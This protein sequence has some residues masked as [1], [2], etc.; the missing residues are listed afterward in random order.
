VRQPFVGALLVVVIAAFGG[1]AVAHFLWPSSTNSSAS[2]P[3]FGFTPNAGSGSNGGGTSNLFPSSGGGSSS[4]AAA[5]PATDAAVTR[6]IDPG[7]VDIDTILGGQGGAAAG[8]GMVVTSNGEVITNNHVIN[9][10]TS[11][12]AYDVGNGRTYTA[13]V[14]GYDRTQ[15]VAVL[16]LQN[17]S[18]LATVPLGDSSTV[19][20]GAGVVTIGNAGGVGGTP[21]AASG[22]VDALHRAITAGDSY[23][24]GNTER[25][26]NVIQI[27]GSLEPGDSGGPLVS[28]GKVVG[29]DTAASSS[30]S[31]QS[32]TAGEGFAIP[33]DEVVS[34][35]HQI[36]SGQGTNI[37]HIGST[38]LIGV[39]ISNTTQCTNESTGLSGGGSGAAGAL[40]CG[41]VSNTPAATTGLASSGTNN[42]YFTITALGGKAVT[43]AQS[44]LSLMDTHHPGDRVTVTWVDAS[45]ASHS[46]SLTLAAGPAD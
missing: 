29:M 18:G 1:A 13:H 36:L 17:A 37:I 15:D 33:I 40:V 42:G 39:Y 22:S 38:A 31:F 8:T 5:L 9:G 3:F 10:A 24:A 20:V 23:E 7:L 28:D 45:G 19:R 26:K 35:S 43:S 41:V 2:S 4:G 30:F 46:A 11:I 14:V 32:S 12:S 6:K 34:I 44:L 27:N 16:Q 21:S 25:L